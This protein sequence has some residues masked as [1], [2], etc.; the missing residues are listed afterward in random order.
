M[1]DDRNVTVSSWQYVE[2]GVW[3]RQFNTMAWNL[4]L[5]GNAG[6]DDVSIYAAPSQA[7]DLSGLPTAYLDVGSGDLL[8]DETVAY[9]SKLWASGVRAELHVWPG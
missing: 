1:L 8:R 2:G 5:D 7:D 9:A 4:V 3:N 6:K